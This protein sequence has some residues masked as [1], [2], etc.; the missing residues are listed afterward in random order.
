MEQLPG[1][2]R[3][4]FAAFSVETESDEESVAV[5]VHCQVSDPAERIKLHDTIRDKACSI[6]GHPAII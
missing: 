3:S 5:L 4:D 1:F 6:L 2:N